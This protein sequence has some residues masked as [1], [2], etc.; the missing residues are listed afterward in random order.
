MY[1]PS[2]EHMWTLTAAL[3]SSLRSLVLRGVVTE[4]RRKKRALIA[5]VN[6][7]EDERCSSRMEAG[8]RAAR[9]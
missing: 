1:V 5:D 9:G 3:R 6:S 8:A 4:N 7:V 2:S